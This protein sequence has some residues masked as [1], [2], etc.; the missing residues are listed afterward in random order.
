MGADNVKGTRQAASGTHK[1]QITDPWGAEGGA[2]ELD[3]Q[4]LL[5]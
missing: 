4:C 1:L 2:H 3:P 5:T